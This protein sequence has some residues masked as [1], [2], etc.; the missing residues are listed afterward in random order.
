VADARRREVDALKV[1]AGV[2]GVLQQLALQAGQSV[3][4]G[5]PLAKVARPDRL[6]AEVRVPEGQAKD[7]TLGLPVTIDTHNASVT[8]H[9][10][11]IDPA[12]QGG[13]V[14][15]DVALDGG[16]P[17]GARPDL[18]VSAVLV[19]ERLA[20]VLYVGRPARSQAQHQHGPLSTGAGQR[21]G[22]PHHGAPRARL[23]PLGRG[24]G[25]TARRRPH[26]SFRPVA[27]GRGR[28]GPAQVIRT[29]KGT[30]TMD[31]STSSANGDRLITLEGIK[32]VFLTD[33][34]ET[35]ALADVHLTIDKGDYIS[36]EGPSGSGKSTLLSIL[37]LLDAP[38][39]GSYLLGGESVANLS[40]TRRAQL[41]NR[42]IGFVFQSFNL[43][44]DLSVYE[45]VE[46]PLTYRGMPADERKRRVLAALERVG[47]GH[48]A[49]HHPGQLSGGQQQ[50]VA[51]AR[52]AAGDPLIVLADEPTGNLD[53]KNGDA[54]MALLGELNRAG[55]TICMVT[56]NPEYARQASRNVNLFDGRVVDDVRIAAAAPRPRADGAGEVRP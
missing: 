16:L 4:A 33:E 56:H 55:A 50:R 36:I 3:V 22:H 11:R 42:S 45:N 52:A 46:L 23:G 41:R 37:G 2:P 9:V 32:K 35:H 7:V 10:S 15:V 13:F 19:L 26:H 48:R 12:V 14:K 29:L 34:M 54:V 38:S 25:G 47:M 18:T 5:A 8:G 6:K 1:R 39:G 51:V 44:G 28:S 43:I 20:N 30:T 53:S 40:P 24:V 49:K 17:S 31:T 21:S 27:M